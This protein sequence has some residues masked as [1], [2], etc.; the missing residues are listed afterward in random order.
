MINQ[1]SVS[2]QYIQQQCNSAQHKQ[3]H[4][5]RQAPQGVMMAWND[6][7][8]L[9]GGGLPHGSDPCS[10]VILHLPSEA[11]LHSLAPTSL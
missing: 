7:S 1:R 6:L 9:D 3:A 5:P 2:I 10:D 11:P 4:V 8:G